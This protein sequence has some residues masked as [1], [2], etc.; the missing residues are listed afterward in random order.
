MLEKIGLPPKPSVRG[1]NWVV[2]ASHCQG[3]SSQFTFINRKHHCRRCGGLFCNSCTQQRMVLRGQGDSPVRIC[4]PCKTLEEAARFEIRYGQRSRAGRGSLKSASKPEY[5]V[6]DQ[7]LSND[8]KEAVTS[9]HGSGSKQLASSIEGAASLDTEVVN[10]DGEGEVPRSRSIDG[11]N[12]LMVEK[13]ATSPDDLRQQ[14]LDEKKKYRQL[15]GEGKSDEALRAFKRGK[16]LERQADALEKNLRK[17]RRKVSLS[18]NIE[19]V[20]IK[21]DVPGESRK[22]NRVGH[23]EGKEKDDLLAELRELGWS[24][25][26]LHNED[27]KGP[28][29]TLEGELFSLLGETSEKTGKNNG[30]NFIDKTQVVAHK[31]KALALKREGNLAE[32]KEEL[33]KA[34]VLEQ[35][36]EEQELLAEA[37]DSDGELS[38]LIC[39]MDN[40][41]QDQFSNLFVQGHDFDFGSLVGAAHD[42]IID[43]SFDVTD[44]DMEDPQIAADLKSLGWMEDSENSE[45]I[46]PQFVSVDREAMLNEILSLKREAVN[47]KRAGNVSE[48]MSLLKKAKLL[49]RD[50]GSFQPQE[51]K[52]AKDPTRVQKDS[53]DLGADKSSVVS[54][55]NINAKKDMD[56]KFAPKSKLLIQKELLGLKKKALALRREGRFDEAEEELKKGK[57][58]EHQLEEMEKALN[59]KTVSMAV[60][61]KDPNLVYEHRDFSNSPHI[62]EER[63]EDVTDQDMHDPTYLSLLRNLGWKDEDNGLANVSSES[64]KRNDNLNASGFSVPQAAP[65]FP[66]AGPRRSRAEMQKELLGLKRK[67]LALRRQGEREEAEEVLRMAEALEAQMAEMELPGKE[68][69]L[70]THKENVIKSTLESED[71][72]GDAGAVTEQDMHDPAML[73]MLKTLGWNDEEQE[74]A[75][76]HDK[77]KENPSNSDSDGTP[78]IQSS[79]LIVVPARSSKG[80]IQRELLNL[81]RKALAL[82]RKGETEEAEE[83]LKNAKA[84]ESEMEKLEA[85]KQEK[86]HEALKDDRH[87]SLGSLV[88]QEKNGNQRGDVEKIRGMSK[89]ISGRSDKFV[90]SSIDIGSMGS[91]TANH[92]LQNSDI[93]I[94]LNSQ[95]IEGGQTILGDMG[96]LNRKGVD[97]SSVPLAVGSMNLM[98]LSTG[99][100]WRGSQ[101]SAEKQM[102]SLNYSSDGSFLFSSPIQSQRLTSSEG[103]MTREDDMKSEK[104]V[105]AAPKDEK[106]PFANTSEEHA[107]QINETALKQDILARKRKAVA[108]KREGKLAEALEELRQA[109]LLEKHLEKD[110]AKSKTNPTFESV[111]TSSVPSVQKNAGSSNITPKPISSRD[112]FKLQQESLAHKRQ[113]LKLRREGRT[114]EAEAEFELAKKLEI[115][116]EELSAHDSINSS[117]GAELE[118]DVG[119]EDFLDPQ[120]LSALKAIGIEDANTVSRVPDRSQSSKPNVDKSENP[121]QERIQ[122]EEQIK[123]EKVKALN[124]KRAGKQAEALDALR[125]AKLFEKKLN[126]FA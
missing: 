97:G 85:P 22:R 2:D 96:P 103:N 99:D 122:L 4:E 15:K 34:K 10:L 94:P 125:N 123:T 35:Q 41:K 36:L 55:E 108:L 98:D 111:S 62:G 117:V 42:Q 29:L 107:S 16:E 67:A 24:D 59:V 70:S 63:E 18:G 21:D 115:Q 60:H 69:Q 64:H 90:E 74:A 76:M 113:A 75:A 79:P 52:V 86:L 119:V 78:L 112:R 38:E 95:L 46:N 11:F 37:E 73:S 31:K 14:A 114:E 83:L 57:S 51:G 19:E 50:L 12:P 116:L 56:S 43:G 105:S 87:E 7:I 110:N 93:S 68:F 49:E 91:D 23:T 120:L 92:L 106:P 45:S 9:G 3:C 65:P 28:N 84:L 121:N 124:L 82:R 40:D 25:M 72:E 1:N 8:R 5:N 30:T 17:N 126:S 39:R 26:E 89:E 71:K 33:K 48:A 54:D 27:K 6:L 80:E 47:Q 61:D 81:K 101:L 118:N 32:A 44:E 109:K 66:V 53:V 13:G 20:Q 77:C 102:D 88:N 100:D 58:L 104:Q